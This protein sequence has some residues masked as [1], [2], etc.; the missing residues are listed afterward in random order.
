M[1]DYGLGLL[2]IVW[3]WADDFV[4]ANL[5]YPQLANVARQDLAFNTSRG[6]S[7]SSS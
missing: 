5:A 4:V 6:L 3:P 7:Q 2:R 1:P